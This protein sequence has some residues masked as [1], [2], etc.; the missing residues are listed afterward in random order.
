[1]RFYLR[2]LVT[3]FRTL[4][5]LPVPGRDAGDKARALPW[6]P[7]VGF[8]LGAILYAAC[9]LVGRFAGN[10]WPQGAALIVLLGGTFLTRAIHLDGLADWA[11]GFWASRD[12]KKVLEVMKD[13]QTGTFGTV[14]LLLV[15][16]VKWV[17]F[18]RLISLRAA[19]WIIAAYVISRASQVHLAV[20]FP[21]AR[22]EPGTGSPFI[23]FAQ[24]RHAV[25]T[26]LSALVILLAGFRLPGVMG[27]VVGWLIARLFGTWCLKR[28]GGVTGDILGAGSEIIETIILAAGAVA[29]RSAV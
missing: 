1:M 28:I 25:L 22:S 20:S 5:I 23:E 27:L 8:V 29:A 3:A 26:F 19:D 9:V 14:V 11:D 24:P 4:T 16:I 12:R 21:C 17:C 15:L 2:G 7:F 13:P 10:A 6:F 18:T